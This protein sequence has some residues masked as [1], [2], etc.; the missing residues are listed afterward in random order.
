MFSRRWEHV[1]VGINCDKP[2]CLYFDGDIWW[3]LR[4]TICTDMMWIQSIININTGIKICARQ[5]L[6]ELP[7]LY[8][9]WDVLTE[10]V[11]IQQLQYCELQDSFSF[12]VIAL[13]YGF[14]G[15]FA[16][17]AKSTYQHV[18]PSVRMHQ[19]GS[20]STHL[21]DTSYW[22]AL[23]K[24]WRKTANLIKIKQK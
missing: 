21:R 12:P 24:I 16:F 4:L 1:G 18:C 17:V 10:H 19:R 13:G 6:V 3:F 14:L 9:S 8:N 15:A 23:M 5:W 22:E 11:L 20:H 2:T 7:G